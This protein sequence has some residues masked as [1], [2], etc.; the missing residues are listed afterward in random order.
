MAKPP[1]PQQ[2]QDTLLS[3]FMTLWCGIKEDK[4]RLKIVVNNGQT[5]DIAITGT[6]LSI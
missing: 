6:G 3:I 2:K 1:T 4:G 5:I